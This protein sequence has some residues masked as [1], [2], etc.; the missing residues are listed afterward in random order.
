MTR[1][2]RKADF[3]VS[4]IRRYLELGPIVLVSSRSKGRA[5]IM[6]MGWHTVMEFVPSLVGCMIASSKYS[7]QMIRDVGIGNT[8]GVLS[9]KWWEIRGGVVSGYPKPRIPALARRAETTPW[10]RIASKGRRRP[11][12][13]PGKPGST[14]SRAASGAA[15]AS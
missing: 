11:P 5:N 2:P 3:P 14:P 10:R 12:C 8:S 1:H 4:Q 9:R 15:S 7:F 13:L 6:A